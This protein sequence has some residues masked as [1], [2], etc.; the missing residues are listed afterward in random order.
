MFL[1]SFLETIGIRTQTQPELHP[2]QHL[3]DLC[4]RLKQCDLLYPERLPGY[5]Q[6]VQWTSPDRPP[7]SNKRLGDYYTRKSIRRWLGTHRDNGE[8]YDISQRKVIYFLSFRYPVTKSQDGV[9]KVSNVVSCR[10]VRH[11]RFNTTVSINK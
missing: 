3:V 1:D 2:D 8:R 10:A 5:Y 9:E 6:F 11:K 7:D 4:P